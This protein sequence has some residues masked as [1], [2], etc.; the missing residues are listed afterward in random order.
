MADA[1]EGRLDEARRAALHARWGD[2]QES[3]QIRE[4]LQ[5]IKNGFRRKR[6]MGAGLDGDEDEVRPPGRLSKL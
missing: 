2:A 4:L 5:A 3:K 6:R 1:T